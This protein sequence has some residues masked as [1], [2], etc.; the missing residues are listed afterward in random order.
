M[1]R[2][3]FLRKVITTGSGAVP[4]V[5]GGL[6]FLSRVANADV[7]ATKDRYLIHVHIAGGGIDQVS[8][9]D[10]RDPSVFTEARVSE[11]RINFGFDYYTFPFSVD[12]YDFPNH[13]LGTPTSWLGSIMGGLTNHLDRMAIIR[14][15]T[16]E[17]VSHMS[18]LG[19]SL[20]GFPEFSITN[21][22]FVS[23]F[24]STFG[25]LFASVF[26]GQ[27]P[28][29]CLY[30]GIQGINF[31]EPAYANPIR[32]GSTYAAYK[33][34]EAKERYGNE[35]QRALINQFLEEQHD[36]RDTEF[37]RKAAT[38]YRKTESLISSNLASKFRGSTMSSEVSS[39]FASVPNGANIGTPFDHWELATL[40]IASGS[41]RSI[42]ALSGSNW[43]DCHSTLVASNSYAQAELNAMARCIEYLDTVEHPDGGSYGERTFILLSGDFYR[44]PYVN[45]NPGRD[46][47]PS[48]GWILLGPDFVPGVY[49]ASTD[50]GQ[51][52]SYLNLETGGLSDVVNGSLITPAN[53]F[54]TILYLTG[55]ETDFFRYRVDPLTCM[56]GS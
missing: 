34:L 12:Q 13:T 49:G 26:G 3:D 51:S 28:L 39:L 33:M 35:E 7:L 42:T 41:A 31:A 47:W 23:D 14:G 18:G 38:G 46:H 55:V 6:P 43:Y 44:T 19:R 8:S 20:F 11:T 36:D 27:E 52:P 2:R 48:A 56:V 24:G 25:V 53:I 15:G 10:A 37:L 22:N 21:G 40:A 45:A 54:R 5:G 17:T 4:L 32:V 16:N 29:P 9:F 1:K 30:S 50:I